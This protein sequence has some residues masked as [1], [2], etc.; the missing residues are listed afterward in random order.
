MQPEQIAA[1]SSEYISLDELLDLAADPEALLVPA[2]AT[3]MLEPLCAGCRRTGREFFR[4]L[5]F[6]G[7]QYTWKLIL[8]GMAAAVS[9]MGIL[10]AGGVALQ[11]AAASLAGLA[12]IV[13]VIRWRPNRWQ[14]Q[15]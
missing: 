8:L 3:P 1:D 9:L 5:F 7:W 6:G 14:Q 15:S 2:A 4:E 10:V 12:A 13:G 11:F